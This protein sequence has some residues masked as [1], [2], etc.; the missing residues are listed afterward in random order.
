MLEGQDPVPDDFDEDFDG[1]TRS[2]EVEADTKAAPAASDGSTVLSASSS[3]ADPS[4][5]LP[6]MFMPETGEVL[7]NRGSGQ[8]SFDLGEDKIRSRKPSSTDFAANRGSSTTKLSAGA[9][10]ACSPPPSPSL[11]Q[12][13]AAS[14][15]VGAALISASQRVSPHPRGYRRPPPSPSIQKL[16]PCPTDSAGAKTSSGSTKF[17]PKSSMKQVAD[18][19][20]SQAHLDEQFLRQKI[21]TEARPARPTFHRTPRRIPRPDLQAHA[22]AV[23]CLTSRR[24]SGCR[25]ARRGRSRTLT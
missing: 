12:S 4:A 22:P 11:P 19:A 9:R 7:E 13:P 2:Y 21:E 20:R 5:A 25:C 8:Q 14:L 10:T 17:T 18:G 15:V 3:Y 16:S 6:P 1:R 24:S 23:L